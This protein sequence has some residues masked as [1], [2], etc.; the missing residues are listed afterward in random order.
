[1]GMCIID[2][3]KSC[4]GN[5]GENLY[6]SY[7]KVLSPLRVGKWVFPSVDVGTRRQRQNPRG[8]GLLGRSPEITN[9]LR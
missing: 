5:N 8:L 3:K 4:G 2:Y 7:Q 1:M 9:T 6:H